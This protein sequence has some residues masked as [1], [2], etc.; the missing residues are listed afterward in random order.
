[1][2][3]RLVYVYGPGSRVHV[4]IERDGELLTNERCNL[5]DVAGEQTRVEVADSASFAGHE[6]CTRCFDVRVG[7]GVAEGTGAAT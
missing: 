6:L 4:A 7:A 3:E 1:M 5:N 2:A